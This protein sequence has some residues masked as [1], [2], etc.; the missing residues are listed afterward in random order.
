MFVRQSVLT[1]YVMTMV[2]GG[3]CVFIWNNVIPGTVSRLSIDGEFLQ[4]S[5][6]SLRENTPQNK[7]VILLERVDS[8]EYMSVNESLK[9]AMKNM[10]LLHVN[11][12]HLQEIISAVNEPH[13][14]HVKTL[15]T[16][17]NAIVNAH[18]F[19]YI[20]NTPDLCKEKDV[21][22]LAYVHTAVGNYKKRMVIRQTWGNN[23]YYPNVVVRVVFVMGMSKDKPELQQVRCIYI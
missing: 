6:K 7:S 10:S 13:G 1:R 23:K 16:N 9:E 12:T 2:A 3:L 14:K 22:M 8:H 5:G 18:D 17:T 19:K 20:L 11:N 4:N 15:K 21:F